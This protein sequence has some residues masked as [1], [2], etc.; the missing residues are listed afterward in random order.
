MRLRKQIFTSK[1]ELESEKIEIYKIIKMYD[2]GDSSLNSEYSS[3]QIQEYENRLK[4]IDQL[5]WKI[6]SLRNNGIGLRYL[7]ADIS[8][9]NNSKAE[10]LQINVAN[11]LSL[12]KQEKEIKFLKIDFYKFL[13]TYIKDANCLKSGLSLTFSG[14]TGTGKTHFANATMLSFVESYSPRSSYY[15]IQMSDLASLLLDKNYKSSEKFNQIRDVDF[16]VVDDMSAE[17]TWLSTIEEIMQRIFRYRYNNCLPTIST[18]NLNLVE[19][20]SYY[21]ERHKSIFCSETHRSL[22]FKNNFDVRVR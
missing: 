5:L 3:D 17:K 15:F 6:D 9:I 8:D 19:F 12:F 14:P 16:L 20:V 10:N 21:G 4:E 18:T 1:N 2:G 11:N 7:N 22:I 13:A